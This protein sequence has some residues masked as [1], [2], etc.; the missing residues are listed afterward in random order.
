[1]T[2]EH[3]AEGAAPGPEESAE[4][5]GRPREPEDPAAAL[6]KARAEIA[7]LQE[8]AA[9][10]EEYLD[11]ARRAKAD[12]INYQDRVRRERQ[13][14]T[15]QAIEQFVREFLAAMDAFTL[16]RF[17]DPKLVEAIRVIEREFLRILAKFQVVPLETVGRTFDPLY[18]EAVAVEERTDVPEGSILE[19][20]RRGWKIGDRVLRPASVRIARRPPPQDGAP[21]GES[22]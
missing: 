13:E 8:K 17:E 18:H 1:M 9:K 20:V 16:A 12:F 10:A 14:W 22:R 6:E 11:L 7:A 15:R 19:E 5:A 2:Q 3:K 4:A 21:A